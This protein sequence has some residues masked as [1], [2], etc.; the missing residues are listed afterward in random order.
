MEGYM[1][2]K[3]LLLSAMISGILVMPGCGPSFF[4][5]PGCAVKA[6]PRA[7]MDVTY[8]AISP[9]AARAIDATLAGTVSAA[10]RGDFYALNTNLLSD[11]QARIS[12]LSDADRARFEQSGRHYD[13]DWR[14]RYTAPFNWNLDVAQRQAFYNYQISQ[15]GMDPGRA[16]V[17]IP[18]SHDL[19]RTTLRLVN[20]GNNRWVINAPDSLSS[21]DVLTRFD[22][23]VSDLS[24]T[25]SDWPRDQNVAAQIAAHRV[26][27]IFSAT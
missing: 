15:D 4:D 25:R 7:R 12:Q 19:P 22:S 5:G 27:D 26:L 24:R 11:D 3:P 10:L 16:L 8:A 18:A 13:T 2:G 20:I 6:E 1:K 17:I 14:A 21:Y 9:A 23:T